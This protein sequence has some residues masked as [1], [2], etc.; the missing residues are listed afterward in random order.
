LTVRLRQF[1]IEPELHR[2]RTGQQ[3][4]G[5]NPMATQLREAIEKLS[6]EI[7]GRA[8]SPEVL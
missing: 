3:N 5:V 8:L 4:M 1:A 7:K 2:W 6:G